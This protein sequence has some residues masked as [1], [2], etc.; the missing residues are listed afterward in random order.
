MVG[1]KQ[2]KPCWVELSLVGRGLNIAHNLVFLD[3]TGI[4]WINL[5]AYHA[6][7]L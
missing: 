6:L 2:T 1:G 7:V 5:Y 3:A 4:K